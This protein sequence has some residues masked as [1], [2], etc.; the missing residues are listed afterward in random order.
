[1]S[2][3][4]L[5]EWNFWTTNSIFQHA[6]FWRGGTKHVFTGF[7]TPTTDL[8]GLLS[9]N[10]NVSI[11]VFSTLH[12]ICLRNGGKSIPAT[13]VQWHSWEKNSELER[14]SEGPRSCHMPM[15]LTPSTDQP[16]IQLWSFWEKLVLANP[17][18]S[19]ISLEPMW[20]SL[21][22]QLLKPG[23]PINIHVWKIC[24]LYWFLFLGVPLSMSWQRMILSL[25]SKIWLWVSL[26]HLDSMTRMG[27]SRMPV[28]WLVSRTCW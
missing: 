27:W 4:R 11:W 6:S 21:L 23:M 8:P 16:T 17:P 28:I 3:I 15:I 24:F 9:S 26:T 18:Q 20:P 14:M 10:W 7:A 19:T 13:M 25:E 22:P 5:H 12:P 2:L 1:M